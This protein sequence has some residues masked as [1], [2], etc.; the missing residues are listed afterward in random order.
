MSENKTV[1]EQLEE[2]QKELKDL[3]EKQKTL[4]DQLNEDDPKIIEFVKRANRV[5][6]YSYEKSDLKR[7]N[8]KNKKSSIMGL[9]LLAIY[10]IVPF[11]FITKP[12]GWILPVFSVVVCACQG[13]LQIFKMKP[14]E[15]ELKYNDIPSFWRYAEFDDNDIVCATKDKWLVILLS[16]CVLLIPIAIISAFIRLIGATKESTKDAI[17]LLAISVCVEYAA[18]GEF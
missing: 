10:F 18:I 5:W 11:F 14:R 12:Y 16:V 2:V 17:S 3:K 6:R 7:K 8:N 13:I 9:V 15:Y 4:V 1:F